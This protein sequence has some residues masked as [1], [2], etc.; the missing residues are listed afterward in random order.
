LNI[1]VCFLIGLAVG[2]ALAAT[3]SRTRAGRQVAAVGDNRNAARALGVRITRTEMTTFAFTGLLYGIAGVLLAG[4][5]GT[6]DATIG[7]PYQLSTI[8]AA[9][10]A[11]AAFGGGPASVASVLTAS[12]FLEL[13]NQSLA[14]RGFSAGAQTIAQG[15][16][17]V[18]AVAAITLTQYGF[19]SVRRWTGWFRDRSNRGLS[20]S[21]G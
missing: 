10:I 9:A 7:S 19:A 4:F 3:L 14:V 16:A 11:G 2:V 12:V 5:V 18:I 20:S 21:S 1:S 13:L 6:P 15:V 17:L 8:T